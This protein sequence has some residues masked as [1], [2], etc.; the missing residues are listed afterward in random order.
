[1]SLYAAMLPETSS[2]V[3]GLVTA[4]VGADLPLSTSPRRR[5][6][7]GRHRSRC[8]HTSVSRRHSTG[9]VGPR[10]PAETHG[11]RPQRSAVRCG[12]VRRRPQRRPISRG[13]TRAA[14]PLPP[15]PGRAGRVAHAS[16]AV[17]RF[18]RRR[19]R[20]KPI[21]DACRSRSAKSLKSQTTGTPI[22]LHRWRTA[23]PPRYTP[24]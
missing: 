3:P 20:L 21:S 8:V 12:D 22:S 23:A 11:P 1:M 13:S 14:S 6:Y 19:T 9:T 10:P 16:T 5:Q 7:C 18:H 17:A 15:A 2:N 4:R 24:T